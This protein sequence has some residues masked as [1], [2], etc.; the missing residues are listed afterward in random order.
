[1]LKGRRK[2]YVENTSEEVK[3]KNSEEKEIKRPKCN[4]KSHVETVNEETE[5][6]SS[7]EEEI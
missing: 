7:E 4:R 6:S 1:M 2:S 3:G 5:E